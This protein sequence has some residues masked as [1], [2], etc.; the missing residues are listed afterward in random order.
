[1][2][3]GIKSR[4]GYVAPMNGVKMETMNQ[5]SVRYQDS[6]E[7]ALPAHTLP[8]L[9]ICGHSGAG[10]TTLIEAMLAELILRGL[11][12]AV[13]K[14]DCRNPVVDIP[15]RDSDRL[16][17][18]G[19]DVFFLGG[20]QFTR[21]HGVGEADFEFQLK[22]LASR[23]DLVLVEGHGQTPIPKIWLLAE[24]ETEVPVET[25]QVLAVF[26]R[27]EGRA[28]LV[29]DFLLQWL[30]EIWQQTPVWACIL[31]GGRSSRMGRPK[32]LIEKEDA[33]D[34]STW[35]EHTVGLLQP[36]IGDQIALSGGGLVPASLDHLPRL[37]D[38]PEA[39]GPLTGILAAMRWQPRVSWLLIACDMPDISTEAVSWLLSQRR[40]GCWGTVPRLHEDGHVEPLLAHY[41]YRCGF[42]FERLLV[43]GS[44]RIGQVARQGKIDSPLIPL[45]LRPSWHNIN[46]PEELAVS[47]QVERE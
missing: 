37:P 16:Y 29:F 47:R 32:H 44:L 4:S 8:I 43:S 21:L 34:N 18:A 46:T 22:G 2:K 15:G 6:Q 35:L 3:D 42:L 25:G 31:I 5:K 7:L 13:V 14:H 41:D 28:P 33:K 19:A 11:R 38:I 36:L 9:G 24:D 26:S 17:R 20:E 39:R 45:S 40:P 23:Y 27:G 30:Q 10:K 12:V 1:M